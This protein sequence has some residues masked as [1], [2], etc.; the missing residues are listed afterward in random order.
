MVVVPV[1]DALPEVT[2]TLPS[3]MFRLPPMLSASLAPE[4]VIEVLV[5]VKL[6]FTE[7]EL[8]APSSWTAA[9]VKLA[10]PVTVTELPA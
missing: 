6:P 5:V 8:F 1:T 4:A 9:L 2:I 10:A 3:V 7:K